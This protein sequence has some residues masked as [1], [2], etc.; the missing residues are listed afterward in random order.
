MPGGGVR[1]AARR[2]E[3]CLQRRRRLKGN[4]CEKGECVCKGR[5]G[6]TEGLTNGGVWIT[7]EG[8]NFSEILLEKEVVAP[9][10]SNYS[11]SST[12]FHVGISGKRERI[13]CP[14]FAMF[15]LRVWG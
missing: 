13:L 3:V 9:E 12:C 11:P 6:R 8:E 1:G 5:V 7:E 2:G 15:K 4:I 14:L 10:A